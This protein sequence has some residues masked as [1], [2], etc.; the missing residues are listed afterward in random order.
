M[1]LAGRSLAQGM[2]GP[3]VKLLQQELQTLKFPI[4]DNELSQSTFGAGT[5]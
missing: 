2:Q 1:K 3:D 4:P 5:H